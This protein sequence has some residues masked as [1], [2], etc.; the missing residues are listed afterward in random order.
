MSVKCSKLTLMIYHALFWIETVK[1]LILRYYIVLLN[2]MGYSWRI[3]LWVFKRLFR[4]NKWVCHCVLLDQWST[5]A[6]IRWLF[7]NLKGR[8]SRIHEIANSSLVFR[9]NI[10]VWI[11]LDSIIAIGWY[12]LLLMSWSSSWCVRLSWT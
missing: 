1:C 4:L 2:N 6:L 3:P 8:A 12:F 11:M 9:H 7:L 10:F 5:C